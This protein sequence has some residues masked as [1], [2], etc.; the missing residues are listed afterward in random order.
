VNPD[1]TFI[2]PAARRVLETLSLTPS[3]FVARVRAGLVPNVEVELDALMPEAAP[4][5]L[6]CFWLGARQELC[7]AVVRHAH[8]SRCVVI[9]LEDCCP[10][11]SA[12]GRH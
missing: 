12:P 7:L 11:K 1:N 3:A 6:A 8:S 4:G 10:F 9:G 2:T 5:T